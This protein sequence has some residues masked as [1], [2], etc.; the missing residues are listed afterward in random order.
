MDTA[1]WQ[2]NV[3]G[4]CGHIRTSHSLQVCVMCVCQKQKHPDVHLATTVGLH[5]CQ[6]CQWNTVCI[7][8]PDT[9]W[10]GCDKYAND[11]AWRHASL[12]H[13][14]H[15]ISHRHAQMDRCSRMQA[16]THT[17]AHRHNRAHLYTQLIAQI[18]L[19]CSDE[20]V[21]SHEYSQRC[22]NIHLRLCFGSFLYT[23]IMLLIESLRKFGSGYIF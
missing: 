21:S 20:Q 14:I 13:I 11:V 2:L 6:S 3:K 18:L 1:S 7:S 5:E 9:Q 22:T 23:L 15:I 17:N 4:A 10:T 19:L 8:E 12:P 16:N